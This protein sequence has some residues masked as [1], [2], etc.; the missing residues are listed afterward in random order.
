MKSEKRQVNAGQD[1]SRLV[2]ANRVEK[3]GGDELEIRLRSH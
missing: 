3:I 2:K 1:Q